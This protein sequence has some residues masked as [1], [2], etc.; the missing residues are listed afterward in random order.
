MSEPLRLS[1]EELQARFL[2]RQTP[3]A[4]RLWREFSDALESDHGPEM[5]QAIY[6]VNPESGPASRE[7]QLVVLKVA[8]T[9]A[10]VAFDAAMDLI[11]EDD[12]A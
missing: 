2:E 5:M 4:H 7:T 3:F 9:A 10:V 6:T 12:P 1:R 8:L 11:F